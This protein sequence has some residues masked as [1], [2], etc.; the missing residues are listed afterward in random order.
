MKITEK[1]NH[2]TE[3]KIEKFADD[4]AVQGG[5]P[6]E[7]VKFEDNILVNGGINLMLTL[8][9]GGGGTV[10]N[11]GNSFIGVGDSSAAESAGQTDLQASTNKTRVLMNFGFPTFGTSQ[12]IVFQSDFTA[13]LGN[14]AWNEF[15]AFNAAAAGTMLNRKVSSQGTKASGQTWRVTLTI[16]IS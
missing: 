14:Y 16:T 2:K 11:G 15:A 7:T 9:A 6:Y 8:L 12:Q 3:W 10:F 4:A 5:H 13:A 1:A